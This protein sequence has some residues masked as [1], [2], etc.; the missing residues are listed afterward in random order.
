M[1]FRFHMFYE[2]YWIFIFNFRAQVKFIFLSVCN[3]IFNHWDFQGIKLAFNR[4]T[5]MFI[6]P[7]V[8]LR[9]KSSVIF[10]REKCPMSRRGKPLF[11][12]ETIPF[13]W[14]T[15]EPLRLSE[16]LYLAQTSCSFSCVFKSWI[17][18]TRDGWSKTWHL[19]LNSHEDS[20]L[21]SA[22]LR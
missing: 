10:E 21:Y 16:E 17:M 22:S 6:N 1:F 12:H 11:V 20:S 3:N 7:P 19:Y 18:L 5:E 8:N 13:K 4:F 2:K 9:Q 15:I 14:V